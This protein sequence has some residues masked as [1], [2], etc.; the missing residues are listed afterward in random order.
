MKEESERAVLVKSGRWS[1]SLTEDL[2]FLSV[3]VLVLALFSL[4]DESA[5]QPVQT[6]TLSISG[7]KTTRV[8]L[9]ILLLCVIVLI[10]LCLDFCCLSEAQDHGNQNQDRTCRYYSKV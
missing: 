5:C 1:P 9:Q 6:Q 2:S 10:V 7:G 8:A 3:R 4:H